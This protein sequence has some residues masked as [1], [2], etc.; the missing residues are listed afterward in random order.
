MQLH[1]HCT[2]CREPLALTL[3][4]AT[5][6]QDA[7][8]VARRVLCAPCAALATVGHTAR[9]EG[10]DSPMRVCG[11]AALAGPSGPKSVTGDHARK[12]RLSDTAL[13]PSRFPQL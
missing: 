10:F 9:L 3:D 5:S 12:G 8:S 11:P 1:T 6:E 2:A 7:T 4:D 13:T